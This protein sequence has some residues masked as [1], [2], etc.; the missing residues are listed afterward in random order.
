MTVHLKGK[1]VF[2]VRTANPDTGP[3]DHSDRDL[4]P[5]QTRPHLLA[6][7]HAPVLR[8]GL[9]LRLQRD[10]FPRR[11]HLENAALAP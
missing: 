11:V 4:D 2:R 6:R 5:P 8:A 1:Y 7:D 3:V 9:A 10:L